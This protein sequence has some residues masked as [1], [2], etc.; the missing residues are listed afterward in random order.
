MGD[1]FF[2]I[3]PLVTNWIQPD[4]K[5]YRGNDRTWPGKKRD[6]A[7]LRL[8]GTS[9]SFKIVQHMQLAVIQGS[10][11]RDDSLRSTRNVTTPLAL[12]CV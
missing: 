7:Y 4:T 3:I 6:Q 11:F 8:V 1:S 12:T 9:S 5:R 2:L 10:F